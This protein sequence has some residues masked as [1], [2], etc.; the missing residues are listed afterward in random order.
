[1]P[2]DRLHGP[3][4]LLPLVILCVFVLVLLFLGGAAKIVFSAVLLSYILAPVVSALES[5]GIGRGI[6][7]FLVLGAIIGV[8]VMA[9]IFIIPTI[10]EQ[11]RALQSSGTSVKA[12][13]SIQQIQEG[14]RGYLSPFGLGDIDFIEKAGNAKRQLGEKVFEFL[15]KD[16]LGLFVAAVAI[17]FMMFFLVK[18]GR[19]LKKGFIELGP[20]RYFEF[21]MD[22]L[23]KMDVQLGNY[24]RSQFIDALVFG[25][26]S[27][28]AMWILGV[29]YFLF[30]GAFAG[31]ANLIPYVGPI[32]GA[33]PAFVVAVLGSGSFTSGLHVIIAFII[34]KIIDDFLVQPF[35]VSRSVG[36]HPL[37]VLVSILIGGGLFGILG[38]LLA[39]PAAGFL[40]VAFRESLATYRMYRFS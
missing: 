34:L 9:G 37:F 5:R 23:Y 36:L 14:M 16:S 15:V 4:E 31:L 35:L 27:T 22:L 33:L 20:N 26:L 11:F 3:K 32:A 21:V 24:L 13:A 39:V 10:L 12:S 30:I 18:D 38:M 1:M 17:P 6:A 25:I 7:T 28:L 29:P 19:D 2:A 8:I 40:K